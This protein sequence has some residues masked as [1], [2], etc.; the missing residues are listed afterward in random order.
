MKIYL[1]LTY[2][3]DF[4]S[5]TLLECANKLMIWEVKINWLQC[6]FE[7][8]TLLAKTTTA[9]T[10]ALLH[11][12]KYGRYHGQNVIVDTKKSRFL[13]NTRMELENVVGTLWRSYADDS[14]N[15]Q[16]THLRCGTRLTHWVYF[17]HLTLLQD[18]PRF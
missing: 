16:I 13:I 17:T 5:A 14:I 7:K 15:P 18:A 6:I 3:P 10:V 9:K 8:R 11:K 2:T 1:I 12:S 4:S